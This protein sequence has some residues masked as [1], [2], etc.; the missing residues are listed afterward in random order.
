MVVQTLGNLDTG[1]GLASPGQAK[2]PTRVTVAGPVAQRD[3]LGRLIGL[4]TAHLSLSGVEAADSVWAAI[5]ELEKERLHVAA[6]STGRRMTLYARKGSR[7]LE[8]HL[9]NFRE[10][11]Y[12]SRLRIRLHKQLQNQR[13]SAT[14]DAL[15]EQLHRDVAATGESAELH[16]P[17]SLAP[18]APPQ[19]AG[20]N[21]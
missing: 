3:A 1:V 7:L 2:G 4:S 17:A 5:A 21:S 16:Y 10:D 9:L 15:L 11:V 18:Q 13:R 12:E 14:A 6:V 19:E 8:A 20:I